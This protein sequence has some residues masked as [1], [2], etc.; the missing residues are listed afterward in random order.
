MRRGLPTNLRG[1]TLR[2]VVLRHL[3]E[4]GTLFNTVKDR[5]AGPGP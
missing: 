3:K 2:R 4:E 1:G 5:K